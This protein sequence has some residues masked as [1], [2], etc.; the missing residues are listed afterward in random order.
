MHRPQRGGPLV[1]VHSSDEMYGADR[2][3]L[4]LCDAL[5]DEERLRAEF[6]LPLD[7]PHDARPLCEQLRARG[8]TVRH[9]DLPVLR[10]AYRH[11]RA[12]LTLL[13][14]MLVL[15][16]AL[17]VARPRTVY[18]ATSAALLA[19]PLARVCG[20]RQV[21]GHVQEIWQ[22][23]DRHVLGLLGRSCHRLL[24]ISDPVGRSL[25]EHLRA[26]THLLL[27]ATPAP[28][29]TEPLGE[30]TG[31]LTYVVASRW[32]G[33]K[34]HRTLFAAW[35]RA[36]CPGRLLVLGGPPPAGDCIDV[37]ALRAALSRPDTVRIVGAVPDIEPYLAASDVVVVPSDQDEP[38]G[39][40]ASE[41]FSH[42]RP[43]VASAGGG[44]LD[45]VTDGVDGW[46]YRMGDAAALADVLRRLDRPHVVAAGQRAR[47]TYLTRFTVDR[48]SREWRALMRLPA[49]APGDPEAAA[50]VPL[51][52]RHLR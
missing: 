15:W 42:G 51:G 29:D 49:R 19:A 22:G 47:D 2:V 46:L 18:C 17:R 4:S 39:L 38:F 37:P 16:R 31:P 25:G 14:R 26:R 21:T 28:R 41:A 40:V 6:W 24:V 50:P 9:L 32:N 45:I 10:R 44:L 43:V 12:V 36:G 33:W 7:L 3:V 11:P 5:T 20:V 13:R 1:F 8:A 52:E 34:G 23:A 35:E 30:R 27:N 48:Y